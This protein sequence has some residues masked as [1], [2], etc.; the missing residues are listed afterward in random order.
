MIRKSN[1]SQG[2]SL[3]L[4]FWLD[5]KAEFH[6]DS[7]AA[8]VARIVS[9]T[10]PPGP[11]PTVAGTLHNMHETEEQIQNCVLVCVYC[12]AVTHPRVD[13][14][15]WD[16]DDL[17]VVHENSNSPCWLDAEKVA[18]AL[19]QNTTI[20]ISAVG[21]SA[22]TY[23]LGK[24]VWAEIISKNRTWMDGKGQGERTHKQYM[25]TESYG[26]WRFPEQSYSF[27]RP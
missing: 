16:E 14:W 22:I 7:I 6:V 26:S 11:H 15:E 23:N 2:P 24:E 8:L 10:H 13:L 5:D 12:N 17:V 9:L 21:V 19:P 3:L 18:L 25:W 1:N 27:S 4:K 20:P